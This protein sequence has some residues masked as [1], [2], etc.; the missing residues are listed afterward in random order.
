MSEVIEKEAKKRTK[1]R[2]VVAINTVVSPDVHKKIQ[3]W[4]LGHSAQVG[5]KF[6]AMQAYTEY[7]K[8][9]TK[10]LPLPA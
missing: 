2:S 6:N 10:D 1:K 9:S 7:L 8:V 3:T 5:K 4:V